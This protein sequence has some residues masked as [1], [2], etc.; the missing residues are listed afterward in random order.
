MGRIS[1][2][3]RWYTVAPTAEASFLAHFF[4]SFW[5]FLFH[6]SFEVGGL[7]VLTWPI[8]LSCLARPPKVWLIKVL[9]VYKII[10]LLNYS[11]CLHVPCHGVEVCCDRNI[12]LTLT[13]SSLAGIDSVY[14]CLFDTLS[15]LNYLKIS[16]EN[17]QTLP[18]KPLKCICY[19]GMLDLKNKLR[20][21]SA[22]SLH[23][24]PGS[25]SSLE[26]IDLSN[27]LLWNVVKHQ[28]FTRWCILEKLIGWLL[29]S[30]TMRLIVVIISEIYGQL[31]DGWPLNV[32]QIFVDIISRWGSLTFQRIPLKSSSQVTNSSGYP[33]SIQI[34]INTHNV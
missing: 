6:I 9:S 16:Q 22:S 25:A 5:A 12:F 3:C 24:R 4:L 32:V 2:L 11:S 20:R 31:L 33:Q 13:S 17:S 30:T 8:L 7:V 19:Q 23:L 26:F 1:F 15:T 27:V 10:S 14:T 21:V 28:W 34:N 29:T 18:F